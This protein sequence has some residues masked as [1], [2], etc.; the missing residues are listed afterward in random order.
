MKESFRA[1]STT[2]L[3]RR[4]GDVVAAALRGPV[5][6]TQHKKARLIVLSVEEYELR[7]AGK[8]PDTRIVAKL[9]DMPDDLAE[10]FRAAAAAYMQGEEG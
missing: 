6:L 1:F 5:L 9:S 10:E 8:A 7:T 4:S 3:S 2:D